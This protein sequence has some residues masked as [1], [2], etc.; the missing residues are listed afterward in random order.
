ML[1]SCRAQKDAAGELEAQHGMDA[2]ISR[3]GWHSLLTRQSL[4]SQDSEAWEKRAEALWRMREWN[5]G[6][7]PLEGTGGGFH[8]GVHSALSA[9]SSAVRTVDTLQQ[10]SLLG[11]SASNDFSQA[12]TTLERPLL[13]MVPGIVTDIQV[14]VVQSPKQLQQKAMQLQ[15]LGSIFQ[16]CDALVT[17]V[18]KKALSASQASQASNGQ[19]RSV[20]NLASTW[21][22]VVGSTARYFDQVEP[23][24]ALQSSILATTTHPLAEG[25]F[26]VRQA[27]IAR[28]AGSANR[29]LQLLERAQRLLKAPQLRQAVAASALCCFSNSCISHLYIYIY[30]YIL[31]FH[32]VKSGCERGN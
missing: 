30:K 8:S 9:L 21:T 3:L 6:N 10:E 19:T 28:E 23:L 27:A 13:K 4:E 5:E 20:L 22:S 7:D 31:F 24:L 14:N 2:A 11:A 18:H 16:C 17:D 29:G 32:I 25:R 12:L 26:L 1:E 15:M